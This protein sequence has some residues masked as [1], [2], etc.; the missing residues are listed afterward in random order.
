[1]I[2]Y[3]GGGITNFTN[4]LSLSVLSTSVHVHDSNVKDLLYVMKSDYCH[5]EKLI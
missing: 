4:G 2:N 5:Y 3:G 1:M